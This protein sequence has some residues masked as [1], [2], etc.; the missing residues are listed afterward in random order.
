MSTFAWAEGQKRFSLKPYAYREAAEIAR[1]LD[2]PEPVAVA[3]V[4]RGHRTVE[5][6]RDFLAADERHDPAEFEGIGKAVRTIRA[7]I[8]AKKLITVHGDYDVDGVTSTAILVRA[9][10]ELGAE[11]DWL[12]PGRVEDG[13]GLTEATVGR[14]AARGTG[15]LVTADCGITSIAEVAA[16]VA[17]GID[18]VVTDHH[19]PGA[20]LPACPIVHPVVSNYP[21][22]DLCAAGVAHKLAA[23]LLG[24]ERAER[25]LD[26][27]ALATVADMVPLTGENRSLVRRGLDAMRRSPRIGLRALMAV[28]RVAPERVSASDISFRLSPRINAAGRLYRADAALELLLGDDPERAA[29]IATELDRANLD[30]RETEREVLA[31][32]NRLLAEL[33]AEREPG[34]AIVL[35]GEGWHPGVVGICAS[36][37]AERHLRPAILI[38]LE[39]DG[40]GKGSGRSVAGF[41]LLAGLRACG[42]HLARFGGHRAAAGLEIEAD[43]LEAFRESF[44][45]HCAP[46]LADGPLEATEEIDAVVGAEAL[47]HELATQMARLGPFGMGNPEVRLLVPSAEIR[48]VRPMGEEG[49]HARF[50]LRAGTAR[51]GGVAFGVGGTLERSAALG[52]HDASVRLELNEWNG[53]VEPRVLLGSLY[54]RAPGAREDMWRCDD[55]EFHQRLTAALTGPIS[56]PSAAGSGEHSGVSASGGAAGGSKSSG[57]REVVDR[58]AASGLAAIAELASS[59]KAVLIV[60]ADALWRRA[61]VE[62]AAH[63]GRFGVGAGAVVAARGSVSRGV[64]AA[65][66]IAASEEGGVVVADWPALSL[67]PGLPRSFRHVVVV[68]P[69][70]SLALHALVAGPA[71]EGDH[72]HLLA[73]GTELSL[74]AVVTALP[75]RDD[76]A[77]AFRAIREAGGPIEG[78]ALRRALCGPGGLS[79]SPEACAL[80]LRSLAE[81]GVVR[82]GSSGPVTLVEVVSS[83]KGELSSSVSFRSIRKAHEECVRYLSQ[84]EKPSSNPLQAAA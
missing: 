36:R 12:I 44:G 64:A 73:S 13:Y 7:A 15:L 67:A 65:E 37:M 57:K 8:E 43:Q 62:S 50:S 71:S 35:W 31:E 11:C 54:E 81:V 51:A 6:A 60:C 49:R 28:S 20:E 45:A 22:P 79:R 17:Q 3:L 2:L 33:E 55:D 38:A 58:R 75:E 4:R 84:P 1:A 30:R 63:P 10:R 80:V 59:G 47:G 5:S 9:I 78:S 16:A 76:L 27:V 41:D 24:V 34:A 40:R 69:A 39:S 70:P 52:P 68:D 53:A 56:F 42:E 21:Y 32:A 18:V 14:L 83:G 74:R 29:E 48:D 23:A 46:I 26:L 82:V 25:D 77:A 19:Q 72:L 66:R 61:I